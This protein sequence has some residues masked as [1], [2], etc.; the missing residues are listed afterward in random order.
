MTY[1]LKRRAL[2]LWGNT[3]YART[4]LRIMEADRKSAEPKLLLHG[5]KRGKW[6]YI[7]EVAR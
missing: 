5:A 3:D 1:A 4:W 6:A 2:I 7:P